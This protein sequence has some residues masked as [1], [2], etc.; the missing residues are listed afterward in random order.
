MADVPRRDEAVFFCLLEAPQ[1]HYTVL[2]LEY[3]LPR[4]SRIQQRYQLQMLT[5]ILNHNTGVVAATW[6]HLAAQNAELHQSIRKV[7]NACAA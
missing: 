2:D 5:R 4:R 3:P 7:A 1:R 6:W